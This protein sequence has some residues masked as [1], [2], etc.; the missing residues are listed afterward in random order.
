[1]SKDGSL[2]STGEEIEIIE[3]H[4][5]HPNAAPN[6]QIYG[7]YLLFLRRSNDNANVYFFTPNPAQGQYRVEI[8]WD[9]IPIYGN[10]IHFTF[11][12]LLELIEQRQ[13]IE[14]TPPPTT[15]TPEPSVTTTSPA[16]GTTTTNP[17]ITT[18]NTTETGTPPYATPGATVPTTPDNNDYN[19]ENGN[20]SPGEDE[21]VQRGEARTV[22]PRG[23]PPTGVILAVVIP[24]VVAG[25]GAG[26]ALAIR[27]K[28]RK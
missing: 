24:V 2:V 26:T 25:V 16:T 14:T 10:P 20:G 7:S 23:N 19:G 22:D 13:P 11:E 5:H 9:F 18:T 8:G 4:N 12:E 15:T 17:Y 27:R 28:H 3:I 6:M 21:N 1:M